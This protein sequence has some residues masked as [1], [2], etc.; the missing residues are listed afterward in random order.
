MFEVL[1]TSIYDKIN[2]NIREDSNFSR[3]TC[4]PLD[5]RTAARCRTIPEL[6]WCLLKRAKVIKA[7]IHS[8]YSEIKKKKYYIAW[9]LCIVTLCPRA[10]CVQWALVSSLI[11]WLNRVS[12]QRSYAL[13]VSHIWPRHT[14]SHHAPTMPYS[15]P[16]WHWPLLSVFSDLYSHHFVFYFCH[17]IV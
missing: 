16:R 3:Y 8:N 12:P 1:L 15:K 7:H 10:H 13:L 2:D 17:K 4:M 9:R 11:G 14:R 6:S 5:N